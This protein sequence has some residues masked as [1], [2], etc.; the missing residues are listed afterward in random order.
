LVTDGVATRPEADPYGA[1]SV[2]ASTAKEEGTVILPV[3]ISA[4]NQGDM[5][6]M[7]GLSSDGTVTYLNNFSELQQLV[8]LLAPQIA[9]NNPPIAID[10]FAIAE[11]EKFVDIP[12]LDNDFDPDGDEIQIQY[13]LIKMPDNGVAVVFPDSIYYF[14]HNSF[15]GID[16]FI[17]QICDTGGLCDEANV[18]VTVQPP[19][20]NGPV[21]NDDFVTSPCNGVIDI[22]VLDN[23]WDDDGDALTVTIVNPSM[24]GSTEVNA[25]GSVTYTSNGIYCGV[26]D[27]FLYEICDTA[28]ACDQALVHVTINSPPTKEPTPLPTQKPTKVPTKQPTPPPSAAPTNPP[29]PVNN[30]PEANDDY[31]TV[32]CGGTITDIPILINDFDPDEDPLT[33][34]VDSE[35]SNGIADLNVDDSTISYTSYT[36]NGNVCEDDT[37]SYQVCDDSWSCDNAIVHITV[38]NLPVANDDFITTLCETSIHVPVM[39]NDYHPDGVSITITSVTANPSNGSVVINDDGTITYTPDKT[40]VRTDVFK[41]QVCDTRDDCDEATVTVTVLKPTSKPSSMPSLLPSIMPSEM[42]SNPPT[43]VEWYYPDW[44]HDKEICINNANPEWIRIVQYDNYLYKSKEECCHKHFWWRITQ[45]MSNEHSMYFSNG[46]KCEQKVYFDDHDAKFTPQKWDAS[47]LFF[48]MEDCCAN[49][50]WWNMT[51]CMAGSP[52]QYRFVFRLDIFELKDPEFCQMANLLAGAL[53]VA[54]ENGLDD[55]QTM[56]NV[57][58]VGC[59]TLT[60]EFETGNPMCGGCLEGETWL[61]DTNGREDTS[62]ANGATSA[63]EIEI[64]APCYH[65]NTE[66]EIDQ[67]MSDM[68]DKVHLFVESG[69]YEF[70]IHQWSQVRDPPLKSL[71]PTKVVSNSFEVLS[72]HNPFRV[73][74][75][76]PW[77]PDWSRHQTCVNDGLQDPYMNEEENKGYYVFEKR[78]DCCKRWFGWDSG[79]NTVKFD[80]ST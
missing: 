39:I 41:Y 50:H 15:T 66:A 78:E 54:M 44:S 19:T 27:I 35:P 49:T 63:V 46:E 16:V 36:S 24:F 61:G 69:G 25:D 32:Q 38:T 80:S 56:V 23:D 33:I 67:E 29:T 42:P 51:G 43:F 60:R 76:H 21:A 53:R 8:H 11:Y 5:T 74:K 28:G 72:L 57:T 58:S 77:Y 17:Y 13:N 6:Y 18:T 65:S 47:K 2:A 52:L 75:N 4:E 30:P 40:C 9:C 26:L 14:P 55:K 1:A 45:C 64:T 62:P 68:I 31:V 70:E 3:Y 20:N 79:C 12:V 37:F 22:L 71:W 59:A 48:T 73:E 7:E 10:D 34:I